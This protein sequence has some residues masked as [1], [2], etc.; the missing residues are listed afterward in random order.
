MTLRC[1]LSLLIEIKEYTAYPGASRT[2]DIG[3][4]HRCLWAFFES[5][6]NGPAIEL[7]LTIAPAHWTPLVASRRAGHM[8]RAQPQRLVTRLR[9]TTPRYILW[10]RAFRCI[11]YLGNSDMQGVC[12]NGTTRSGM[13]LELFIII[14][15]YIG[16][17]THDP[18][19][20]SV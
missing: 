10:L 4:D 5:V 1:S 7:S 11:P 16:V 9:D 12:K 6:Q 14:L 13:S 19:F 2:T 20:I 3:L 8:F 18:S 17:Q 15:H